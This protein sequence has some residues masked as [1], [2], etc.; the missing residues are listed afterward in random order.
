MRPQ[1]GRL[2]RETDEQS[3]GTVDKIVRTKRKLW[4]PSGSIWALATDH[5]C[6]NIP[7]YDSLLADGAADQSDDDPHGI[8]V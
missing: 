8:E 4:F 3:T 2:Y 5:G 6:T 7:V 1:I